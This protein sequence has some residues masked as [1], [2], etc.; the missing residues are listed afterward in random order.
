ML[1]FTACRPREN[2][3]NHKPN[4]PKYV[5]PTRDFVEKGIKEYLETTYGEGN[6]IDFELGNFDKGLVE[7]FVTLKDKDPTLEESQL[8]GQEDDIKEALKELTIDLLKDVKNKLDFPG[9]AVLDLTLKDSF[10][11]ILPTEAAFLTNLRSYLTTTWGTSQRIN[12][13]VQSYPS[14]RYGTAIINVD[15]DDKNNN[16]PN[17]LQNQFTDIQNNLIPNE[18][19]TLLA[20]TVHGINF[21]GNVNVTL[22]LGTTFYQLPSDRNAIE[23]SITSYLKTIDYG[24]AENMGTNFTWSYTWRN[25]L[26]NKIELEIIFTEKISGIAYPSPS[27]KT[28]INN[29]IKQMLTDALPALDQFDNSFSGTIENIVLTGI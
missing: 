5:L 23:S 19:K 27:E 18:A 24:V 21:L 9:N 3:G 7:V 16:L 20:D 17:S 13:T 29:N 2:G 4:K 25:W 22:T 8:T 26:H 1:A 15:L 28:N 6:E 12:A 11:Y 10:N 14:D